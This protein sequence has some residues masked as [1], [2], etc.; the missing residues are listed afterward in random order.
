MQIDEKTYRKMRAIKLLAM[1]VDGVLTDGK[2]FYGSGGFEGVLFNVQDGSGIKWLHRAGIE[3]A[4]ITGRNLEAIQ[5]RA[6]ALEIRH[7]MQGAKVKLEAYEQLKAQ[8]GLADEVIC[9]IGDD[10]P[11]IPIMKRAGLAVA[12]QGAR[13]EVLQAA[14]IVTETRGGE[15]AVREVA[16]NILKTQGRWKK[17]VKPYFT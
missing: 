16:E 3:T 8:T 1:D 12:V 13:T 10:L 5:T 11:D 6:D 15:G 4:L 9:Y 2:A 17:I 14:H 7:V